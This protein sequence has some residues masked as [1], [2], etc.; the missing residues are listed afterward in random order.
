[1]NLHTTYVAFG[2]K[3]MGKVAARELK[4]NISFH[5]QKDVQSKSIRVWQPFFYFTSWK[6]INVIPNFRAT[7]CMQKKRPVH[8]YAAGGYMFCKVIKHM[9]CVILQLIHYPLLVT[10]YIQNSTFTIKNNQLPFDTVVSTQSNF[11]I[12]IYVWFGVKKW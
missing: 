7:L 6:G 4:K 2:E 9:Y 5:W 3:K 8:V 11:T 12:V 10:W 1:M